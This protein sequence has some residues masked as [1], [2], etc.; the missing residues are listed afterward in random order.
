MGC[1]RF[2]GLITPTDVGNPEERAH[3]LSVIQSV[4]FSAPG[5][6]NF[7]E[8]LQCLRQSKLHSGP[9][10]ELGA[11]GGDWEP[12]L[13]RPAPCQTRQSHEEQ[14]FRGLD[15]CRAS[16]LL[17][18]QKPNILAFLP[19]TGKSWYDII[20]TPNDNVPLLFVTL[21]NHFGSL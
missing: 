6:A 11:A 5:A 12:Q 7:G 4:W 14:P 15:R 3:R 21:H 1:F 20:L 9:R 8:H 17:S 16:P 18:S 19:S 2:Y 13:S 10:S